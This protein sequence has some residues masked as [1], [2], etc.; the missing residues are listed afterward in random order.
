MIRT[1]LPFRLAAAFLLLAAVSSVSLANDDKK[2]KQIDAN[3]QAARFAAAVESHDG[4]R[5]EYPVEANEVF[6]RWT[7]DGL[8]SLEAAGIQFLTWPGQ[9]DLAR[10]VFG[11]STSDDDTQALISALET[12]P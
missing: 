11:H 1:T 3:A 8:A 12:R 9:P 10:F 2:R 4:A 5:L 7:E 6:V